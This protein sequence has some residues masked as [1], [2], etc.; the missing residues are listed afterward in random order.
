MLLML[1]SA[2]FA[3]LALAGIALVFM[4]GQFTT[5]DGLFFTGILALIAA[6]F[7]ANAAYEFRTWRKRGSKTRAVSEKPAPSI[8]PKGATRATT[9]PAPSPVTSTGPASAAVQ[10]AT[11]KPAPVQAQA[12]PKAAPAV[13]PKTTSTPQAAPTE[14]QY[15]VAPGA[16]LVRD[17][18]EL[19]DGIGAVG[20]AFVPGWKLVERADAR[21]LNRA[22]ERAGW[23]VFYVA[24]E[25]EGATW[26]LTREEAEQRVLGELLAELGTYNGFE[27]TRRQTRRAFGWWHVRVW[28]HAR[29]VQKSLFLSER[30]AGRQCVPVVVPTRE[31]PEDEAWAA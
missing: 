19:P 11:E 31:R 27:V 21:Q 24:A 5:V 30:P 26:D 13:T 2:V 4:Q 29:Q 10:P 18:I 8:E 12:E 17:E 15:P 9:S 25:Y 22:I 6:V 23:H 20:K 7:G 3:V 1:T 14:D 28:G 16:M